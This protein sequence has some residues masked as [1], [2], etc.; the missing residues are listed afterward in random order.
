M[1]A[2]AAACWRRSACAN[3]IPGTPVGSIRYLAV[4]MIMT[5]RWPRHLCLAL[6]LLLAQTAMAWHAPSH[7]LDHHGHTITAAQHDCQA[8]HGHGM[9]CSPVAELPPARYGAP[10]ADTWPVATAASVP[11]CIHPARAPPLFS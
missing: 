11:P 6:L 5:D 3:A 2:C 1:A 8:L 9:A 4:K 10:L 7:I